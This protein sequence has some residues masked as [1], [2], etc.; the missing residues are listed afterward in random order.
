MDE[1]DRHRGGPFGTRQGLAAALALLLGLGIALTLASPAVAKPL[2]GPPGAAAVPGDHLFDLGIA[3]YN[4]DGLLDMFT[5]NHKFHPALLLNDGQGN[6][7]DQTA[8]SGFGPTPDFPG[9]ED[10]SEPAMSQPGIYVYA[11]DPRGEKLPGLIHIRS[12]G[13]QAQGSF[14]FGADSATVQRADGARTQQG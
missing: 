11:S 4:G 5:A 12:I 6:F 1:N 10:L 14:S 8:D 7:S 2:F 13:V 9:Y 3:D